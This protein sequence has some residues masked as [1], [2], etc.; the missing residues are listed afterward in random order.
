MALPVPYVVG[1]QRLIVGAEDP[2]GNPVKSWADPV[3]WPV[4]AVAPGVLDE[5]GKED[6]DLSM[7]WWTLLGPAGHANQPEVGDRVVMSWIPGRAFEVD[8]VPKDY[9]RPFWG[10]ELQ[11][12]GV[13]VTLHRAE[14]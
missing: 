1:V 13:Q 6:R 7:E 5:P 4:S 3:D 2:R 12:A 10:R 8:G 11:N 14:G 9:T